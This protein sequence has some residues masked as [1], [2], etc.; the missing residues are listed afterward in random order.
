MRTGHEHPHLNAALENHR[1]VLAAMGR[2]E[3]EQ[4]LEIES[5]IES[6]KRRVSS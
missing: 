2:D 6:A 1:V 5:L 4:Q 3:K